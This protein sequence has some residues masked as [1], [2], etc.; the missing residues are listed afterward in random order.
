MPMP[1]VVD[2]AATVPAAGSRA[3]TDP[4]ASETAA[5]VPDEGSRDV[6][7]PSVADV[8]ATVPLA[9]CSLPAGPGRCRRRRDRARC[10]EPCRHVAARRGHRRGRASRAEP[11]RG[12]ALRARHCGHRARR[13]VGH[14]PGCGLYRN[15]QCGPI[16]RASWSRSELSTVPVARTACGRYM[17]VCRARA[18]PPHQT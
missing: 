11:G 18:L 15:G 4:E 5:T 14:A 6:A 8:A 2:V 9:G 3:V 12:R 17:I 13:R 16:A 7:A 1:S 10:R